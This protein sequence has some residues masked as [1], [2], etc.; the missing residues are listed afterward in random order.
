[1][2]METAE[3]ARRLSNVISVG[4]VTAVDAEKSAAKVQIGTLETPFLQVAQLRA[5]GLQFWWMPTE[6]EQV[7]VAAPSGDLAQGLIL[8]SVFSGNAPSADG[9]VPMVGLGGGK[10]VFDGTIEVTGDVVASGVSLVSHTH[11]GVMGGP[12]NTGEPN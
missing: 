8:L 2:S 3:L 6:G 11:K 1:M 4:R 5:G 10:M 7:I 9:D 12:S